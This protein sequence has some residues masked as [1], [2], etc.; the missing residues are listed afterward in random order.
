MTFK[1][2]SAMQINKKAHDGFTLLELMV[3]VIIIGIFA[4]LAV[5][6]ITQV[7]Y[8][9][10]LMI[11]VDG[12]AQVAGETRALAMQ[13]RK[14][15]VLEVQKNKAWIR[16]LEGAECSS[17]NVNV[18]FGS[19]VLEDHIYDLAGVGMCGGAALADTGS[20]CSE[21]LALDRDD[22]F[23]LCYTGWGELRV[24]LGPNSPSEQWEKSCGGSAQIDTGGNAG[25]V[26]DG[27]TVVFNR[28]T[29][30]A[31]C[32]ASKVQDVRRA[33]IF[34]TNGAPY[35]RVKP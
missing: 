4:A 15:V 34:P 33:V 28:F 9:N 20:G 14:A 7:R 27:A 11:M 1:K 5:P 13:T 19:T 16:T 25:L 32:D 30:G 26:S 8:R 2:R 21:F 22:G 18:N 24:R 29:K 17:A 12:F 31:V 3:V 10:Y 6:S 35:S 23:G